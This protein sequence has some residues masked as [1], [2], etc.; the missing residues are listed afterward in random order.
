MDKYN[1]F[2]G[3]FGGRYVPEVLRAPLIELENAYK[4]A[5]E[6]PDFLAELAEFQHT[7]IGR[8]T[9]L[10]HAVNASTELGGA[11]IYIKLEGLANTGAHKINNAAGQALLAK[12]MGKKRIIAETGAGQH[13]VATAS[14]CAKLGLECVIYMGTEDIRRQRP[15]VYWMELF[16]AEVRGVESGSRTLKD[17]VN[18]AFR[19]WT[20]SYRDTHYLL[21]SALGPSPFPDMVREFQSVIGNEVS[22]Q[23]AASEAEQIDAMVACVGGGSNAIGFFSP[24]IEAG[25]PR[26][27]GVEAGGRGEGR[28]NNAVR[29]DDTGRP[30]IVQGY[31][32]C[33]LLDED[34]QVLPTHSISAGLDYPGIGPQ[35][36][37]LGRSGRLEF[38]SATDD[39]ALEALKFFAR[40]EGI[41]F[42][43][44]SAHAGA[45]AIGLA[46]ELGKGRNIVVNMSGRGDKD[47]FISAAAL[48]GA[49]WKD[50]LQEEAGRIR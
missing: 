16:G 15:N 20:A 31:K 39:E 28:G 12:R 10:L 40:T 37:E 33:F 26:L 11:D 17:A 2:F 13:G 43:M 3:D 8:P 25:A 18:E 35:L 38:Q 21:G 1:N 6:D 24:Y 30:G 44:E 22:E 32:S 49:N 45:A 46:K 23:F 36:A 50:F 29:M 4:D 5:V 47:I 7:F 42:A 9:P 19:D 14:A 34:G 41:I 48:D 27:I